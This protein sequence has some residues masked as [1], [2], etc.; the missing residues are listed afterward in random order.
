MREKSIVCKFGG[1]SVADASLFKKVRAIV[2]SNPART[3]VVVSAPGKRTSTET[4]LTDLLYAVHDLGSRG[5][6]FSK[7]FGLVRDRFLEI[8]RDLQLN[9]DVGIALDDIEKQIKRDFKISVG[10]VVSRGEYLS[11]LLMAEYLGWEFIDAFDLISINRADRVNAKGYAEI[12]HR[13]VDV[14]RVVVPGF[15]AKNEQ[16]ELE[17]FSRGGSDITGAILAHALDAAVYE[18]WTDVSGLL[19]ADP[20]IISSPRSMPYVSYREIRELS[21]SGANVLHDEAIIPCKLKNIPIN[22]RNTIHPE[23]PGTIIGPNDKSRPRD[24]VTGIAG[25]LNF[26][27]IYIDKDMMNKKR[28]FGASVMGIL[29][30]FG[31]SYEHAPTGI[32]SMSVIIETAQL[33][34]VQERVIATL[35]ER[36]EPNKVRVFDELALIATVGH[37]MT[38]QVGIAA[39]LFSALAAR[40]VNVRTIDQ[41]S[42][43]INIIVGVSHSD[44]QAAIEAIYTEFVRQE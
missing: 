30:E 14:E 35:E 8:A 18:N 17:T 3:V 12:A 2:E 26:S 36:L 42:S 34:P 25:R 11:A 10:W 37:G 23:D 16:G 32:D 41:G 31:I 4:K 19:M 40:R 39:R 28:G 43:E 29:D 5:Q 9:T 24:I 44:F 38:G 1:S 27:M 15:Y 6:D 13:L 21:Y 20:R 22:I 33:A 7:P